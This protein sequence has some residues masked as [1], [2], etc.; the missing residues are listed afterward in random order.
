MRLVLSVLKEATRLQ[1]C[2]HIVVN[3]IEGHTGELVGK[4]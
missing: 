3:K 1:C 4:V 2:I